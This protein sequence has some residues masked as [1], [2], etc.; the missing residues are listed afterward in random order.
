M[1]FLKL[2]YSNFNNGGLLKESFALLIFIYLIIVIK[3]KIV[4]KK[5]KIFKYAYLISK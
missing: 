1:I 3:I 5:P 2:L 4:F